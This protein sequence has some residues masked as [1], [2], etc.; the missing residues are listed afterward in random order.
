MNTSKK[1]IASSVTKG[2]RYW[3]KVLLIQ[4]LLYIGFLIHIINNTPDQA[5]IRDLTVC[6]NGWFQPR[7]PSLLSGQGGE[8]FAEVHYIFISH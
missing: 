2:K 8:A 4:W 6:D 5:E 7:L 1:D 3:Y